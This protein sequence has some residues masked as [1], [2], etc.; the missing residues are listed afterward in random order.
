MKR[1]GI[2][3]AATMVFLTLTA[4][5]AGAAQLEMSGSTTVQKR[6]IEPAAS[7]IEKATGITV[8][9]RGINSGKGFAE[10]RSG[11][12]TASVSSSPLSLLLEKAGLP[13]DGT[14]QEHVIT[15]DVIVP[16]VHN[17]NPVSRLSWKQL[18]DI[19]AGRITN[20]KDVGGPE[21]KIIVVTSQPTAA[22]RIVFQKQVMK[23]APYV[24]GAREVKSTRQEVNLVAKYKGGIGAVSESFV[25]MNRGKVKV[26]K[27]KEISRPLSI[28]TRGEPAPEVKSLI[29]FLRKPEAAK[30]FK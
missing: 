12:V 29:D 4:L 18:A 6:I 25:A 22:T 28:I 15:K 1:N 26:I 14:Y 24:S 13:D 19:N 7:A 27:T 2:L 10:L 20:W 21:Q 3:A 9:V 17:S 23:K 8:R 30:N 11:K 16:I 5:H